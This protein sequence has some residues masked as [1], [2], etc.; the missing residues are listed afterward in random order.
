MKVVY[1][2][3]TERTKKA[4]ELLA[5]ELGCE[6]FE[7]QL[8]KPYPKSKVLQMVI[9]GFQVA[10]KR[11]PELMEMPQL[12]EGEE[13]ILATPVWNAGPAPAIRTFLIKSKSKPVSASLLATSLSGSAEKCFAALEELLGRPSQQRL[14]LK[15][16]SELTQ[17]HHR[18]LHVFAQ[19][20]RESL[21]KVR[22]E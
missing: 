4:A 13:L 5:A 15:V 20:I 16:G 11:T 2:S 17:E 3:L 19:R 6:L 7:L 18:Q 22:D 9:G 8:K 10:A 1:Y 12:E 14:S 21:D